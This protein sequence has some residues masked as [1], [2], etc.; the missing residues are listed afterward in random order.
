MLWHKR[1]LVINCPEYLF[2]RKV[3]GV[4]K[5]VK[6]ANKCSRTGGISASGQGRLKGVTDSSTASSFPGFPKWVSGWRLSSSMVWVSQGSLQRWDLL[7]WTTGGFPHDLGVLTCS[8]S[9][10]Y[11]HYSPAEFPTLE[12]K[13]WQDTEHPMPQPWGE[14][15]L[16]RLWMHL[17]CRMQ[18][19]GLQGFWLWWLMSVREIWAD[20]LRHQCVRENGNGKDL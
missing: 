5:S 15:I 19:S 11:L 3:K 16:E 9:S 17:G 4:V 20:N 18:G 14:A 13:I 8:S 7:W 6:N 12:M 2:I 1:S 10:V